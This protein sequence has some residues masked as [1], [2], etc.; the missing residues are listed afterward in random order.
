MDEPG[1][2]VIWGWCMLLVG[3]EGVV[4]KKLA[5]WAKGISRSVGRAGT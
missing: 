5:A 1:K 4:D 3:I 2:V